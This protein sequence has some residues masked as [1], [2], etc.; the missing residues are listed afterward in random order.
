MRADRRGGRHRKHRGRARAAAA[1]L[2]A[3]LIP[4]LV[5]IAVIDSAAAAPG[6]AGASADSGAGGRAQAGPQLAAVTGSASATGPGASTLQADPAYPY[7][8]YL[9]PTIADITPT[10]VTAAS[11]D[12][13]TV[14]G[15]VTNASK[16]TL[17]DLR[18]V[19]QRGDPLVTLK[20]VKA[21][22]AA[23]SRPSV[24]VG[25]NWKVL[26]AKPVT[27][28]QTDLA[29]GASMEFVATVGISDADGLALR[30]GGVYPLMIKVSGD[31]GQNGQ[32]QYERVGEIHL[33]ATVLSVPSATA[34]QGRPSTITPAPPAVTQSSGSPSGTLETTPAAGN[35][36]IA[37]DTTTDIPT[38]GFPSTATSSAGPSR[39]AADSTTNA[40]TGSVA[41]TA[42]T[43]DGTNPTAAADSGAGPGTP[44]AH[45]VA[46]NLL[47]PLVD[48]PHI[49][50]GGVF[51]DDRL[52]NEIAPTGRLGVILT[53]LIALNTGASS[54]T[55]VVD[56][57]L[58]DEVVQMSDGYRVV[59]TPGVPQPALTPATSAP[60]TTT[61]TTTTAHTST[62][63]A[64]T[65]TAPRPTQPV[66]GKRTDNPTTNRTSAAVTDKATTTSEPSTLA[67][68]IAGTVA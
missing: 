45:P 57:E 35:S 26:A 40:T 51:L 25:Q 20:A 14:T 59:A 4:L 13:M 38:Q 55:I 37:I 58:L 15:T 29:A 52:A 23:P 27:A 49:G 46:L 61:S 48:S 2:L 64:I 12:V 1:L 34:A 7:V 44:G 6:H 3:A 50:V 9:K 19:W 39:S 18:Y 22:I 47:W 63:G 36:G 31:V 32:I 17:Y 28:G 42:R 16:G 67:P 65:S 56:P 54:T 21:E 43:G 62:S 24:V 60:A 30:Q 66:T 41:T 11:G 8:G 53:N 68:L 33:L 5:G 10:V